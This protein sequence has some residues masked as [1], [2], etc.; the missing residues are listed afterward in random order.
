MRYSHRLTIGLTLPLAL[1]LMWLAGRFTNVLA[2]RS[3]V[4][5][6]AMV[7]SPPA[8]PLTGDEPS[9]ARALVSQQAITQ[10]GTT[11]VYLPLIFRNACATPFNYDESL[12]YNLQKINAAQAWQSCY[13]GQ[14]VTVA[15]VD[16]GI[17]LYHPDLQANLV[18]GKSFVAGVSSPDDDYGHGTHVA[19]IVA[20][21]A[22]NGGII[23]VAPAARLM[24]VKVLDDQGSGSIYDV[25]E[26]IEW[27]ADHG[28]RVV[29][30]SLGSV[31]DSATLA[32][33]VDYA[34]NKGVL[35][36]A[37]G[38]NCGGASYYLNGCDY[39]NQ[40]IYPAAY[41]D[42]MA[43]AAT[44]SSDARSSFSTQGSYIEIAAPGS[45]IYSTYLDG[46]YATLS[47]TSMA[48]PHVAGLA[49]LIWSQNPGWSN[50]QV[51]A[52]IRD[53]AQDLG[54][55]GWDEQYGYG[56][57]DAAAAMGV[58]QAA[59]AIDAGAG[60]V[61]PAR[62][63]ASAQAAYIPGEILVKLRAGFTVSAVMGQAQLGTA[64]VKVAGTLNQLGVQKLAV[65]AGREQAVLAQLRASEGVAYAEL[66]Y[67]VT[68]R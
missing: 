56:R 27:A 2:G 31:S 6:H 51:R 46:G 5:P 18:T 1:S 66:N 61:E 23:G 44:D 12:T 16:T 13:Q 35:L 30:L 24:P 45:S 3:I 20:A 68:V 49:A 28:A 21:V 17:D 25:A 26:G 4:A 10:T 36:V 19:G 39:Q 37:A 43:V 41:A 50:R 54:A 52:R 58:L 34:Y 29:N 67:K 8:K 33:V 11:S 32:D 7:Q 62:A 40:P 48:T 42:V 38:G 65:T 22:N 14:G 59:A 63:A 47:G 53:T 55:A 57:I 15:V 9:D 64:E 60:P